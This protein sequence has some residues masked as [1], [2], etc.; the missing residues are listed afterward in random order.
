M[1]YD[2]GEGLERYC[3]IV[4]FFIGNVKFKDVVEVSFLYFMFGL[5]VLVL[6]RFVVCNDFFNLKL[7]FIM[8]F[9]ICE[10]FLEM[11]ICYWGGCF[12]CVY[13]VR[14]FIVLSYKFWY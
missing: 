14:L 2:E 4:V 6:Y 9:K 11:D 8:F 3:E 12:V 10:K 1:K 13:F 7:L 5:Y